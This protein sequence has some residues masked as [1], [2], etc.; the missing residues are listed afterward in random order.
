MDII[1][2]QI[3][4]PIRNYQKWCDKYGKEEVDYAISIEAQLYVDNL[5]EKQIK[6]QIDI[7]KEYNA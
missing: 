1:E 7:N 6:K 3:C 4:L 5:K 2:L